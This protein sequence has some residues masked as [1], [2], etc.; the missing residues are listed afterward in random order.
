MN[1]YGFFNCFIS[2]RQSGARPI[3]QN[4]CWRRA[5]LGCTLA[6]PPLATYPRSSACVRCILQ[7]V[8][9]LVR[10]PING[11]VTSNICVSPAKTGLTKRIRK[12]ALGASSIID[13]GTLQDPIHHSGATAAARIMAHA[14]TTED[15]P[16]RGQRSWWNT[17]GI[18]RQ[19]QRD[20]VRSRDQ[21][22]F[23]ARLQDT[24]KYS[25]VAISLA[26]KNGDPYI[27]GYVPVIVAKI[28]LFL[29]HNGA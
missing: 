23:G 17:L 22:I 25:S 13:L 27:W 18:Q 5:Q 24:L 16:P 20:S 9:G 10:R 28:G 4:V 12:R 7:I 29:K 8:R 11:P 2:T 26:D 14:P 6:R 19:S 15:I 21:S 3:R 1:V